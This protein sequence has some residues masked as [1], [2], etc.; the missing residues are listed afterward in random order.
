MFNK[1]KTAIAGECG[2]PSVETIIGIAVALIMGVALIALGRV[3]VT[4]LSKA[5]DQVENMQVG[6]IGGTTQVN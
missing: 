3:V 5:S 2:G 4:W 1:M 6:G